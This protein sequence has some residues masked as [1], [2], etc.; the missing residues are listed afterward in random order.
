MTIPA[1][2]LAECGQ[3][4]DPQSISGLSRRLAAAEAR[5]ERLAA[6]LHAALDNT[7]ENMDLAPWRDN[8]HAALAETQP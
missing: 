6:A 4:S 1:E 5:A 7:D 3:Q 2:T 8:A